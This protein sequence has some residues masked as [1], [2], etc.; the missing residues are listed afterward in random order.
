VYVYNLFYYF[1]FLKSSEISSLLRDFARLELMFLL[2][3]YRE[4]PLLELI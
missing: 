1:R 2:Q 3:G 4:T